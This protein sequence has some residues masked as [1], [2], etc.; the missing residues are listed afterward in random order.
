MK[1]G[2]RKDAK[3]AKSDERE[4]KKNSWEIF[5]T[6]GFLPFYGAFFVLLKHTP[7]PSF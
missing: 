7:G 5:V 1:E 6:N 2:N 3:D 4:W